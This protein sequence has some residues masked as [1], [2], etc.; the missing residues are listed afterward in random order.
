VTVNPWVVF[1]IASAAVFLVSVDAT[2]AVAAFPALRAS[3]ADTSPATLSWVLNAYTILYAALLVPA[4]RL[5]DLHGAKRLFLFGV[6]LFTL[7]SA[8]CGMAPG[9]NTLIAA[10]VVQAVGGAV[11]TPASLALILGA[12]PA[13]KRSA[14]VGLWSAAGALGAAVGPGAGAI[15]IELATWRAAFLVNLPFGALILIYA[16]HRLPALKGADAGEGLDI[17]G[18]ALIATGVAALTYGVV[19]VKEVGFAALGV[20]GPALAGI[21][22]LV[23]YALWARG[24]KGAAID[25]SLFADRTHTLVTVA[26]FVFGIAFSMMFLSS[27]LFLLGIWGYSQGLTGLAVTPGP[28]VVIAVAIASGRLV[29]RVG[30]RAVL[31]AGGV[32]YAVAQGWVAWHVAETPAYLTLWF[33]MQIVGGIA[34]GLLLVGLS[35][36]AV[37][38]LPPAR[39]GVGGAVNNAVRQLGGV[40]GTALAVVLVGQS[41]AGIEA[42]RVAF[43][44]LGLIGL[45]TAILCLPLPRQSGRAAALPAE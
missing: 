13:G 23:T 4:G 8:A 24:R 38:G 35:G 19:Q 14:I 30:H 2:I 21:G 39:F 25:M 3:F 33:P 9:T 45:A 6:A 42:F 29:A 43:A 15:L 37:A 18:I 20:W 36:A 5:V 26:S 7:A 40:F 10:R 44:C 11:L 17:P 16:T 12:F 28:L 32:L 22:L 34:V 31:V 1:A 27:F 41:G